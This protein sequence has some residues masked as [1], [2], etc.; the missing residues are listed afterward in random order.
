MWKTWSAVGAFRMHCMPVFQFLRNVKVTAFS[1]W[2]YSFIVNNQ[3]LKPC[4]YLNLP[5]KNKCLLQC[6][7]LSNSLLNRSTEQISLWLGLI[8]LAYTDT[9]LLWDLAIW[10]TLAR[11]TPIP[12]N[13]QKVVCS[14]R[15][16]FETSGL[17]LVLGLRLGLVLYLGLVLGVDLRVGLTSTMW[18][19]S[20]RPVERV[21]HTGIDPV[22]HST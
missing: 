18:P 12:S 1:Q 22:L 16:T 21:D 5:V 17:G 6:I 15:L 3:R 8:A 13:S 19:Y 7:F 4:P 9:L 20:S 2:I 10:S 14:V 11:S